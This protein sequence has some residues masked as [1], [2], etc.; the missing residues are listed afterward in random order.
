MR[1]L[2]IIEKLCE[3]F[4]DKIEF[5]NSLEEKDFIKLANDIGYSVEENIN[6]AEFLKGF[7]YNSAE[8]EK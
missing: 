5:I 2:M 1:T 4:K 3:L 6:E 8:K 7:P